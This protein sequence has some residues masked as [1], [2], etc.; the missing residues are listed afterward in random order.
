MNLKE[1]LGNVALVFNTE[2]EQIQ[3]AYK[4]EVE[5]L[6]IKF[7]GIEQKARLELETKQQSLIDKATDLLQDKLK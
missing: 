7:Q 3:K 6:N 4:Q 2:L 5:Q 1:E